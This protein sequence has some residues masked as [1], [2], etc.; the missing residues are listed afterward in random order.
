MQKPNRECKYAP[1]A[2]ISIT[3]PSLNPQHQWSVNHLNELKL[4][5]ITDIV[6]ANTLLSESFVNQLNEKFAKPAA[7]PQDAH[8]PWSADND[9]DQIL[10]WE[11]T[12]QIKNDWTVQLDNQYFQIEKTTKVHPKQQITIRRH[13]DNSI[14]LWYKTIRLPFTA[15]AK[16][17]LIVKSAQLTD[18]RVR[19]EIS[20]QNKHK[21]P[22]SRFNPDWLKAKLK[23][24]EKEV[25]SQAVI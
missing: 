2:H 21:T 12:R 1:V 13:L 5:K 3:L 15:I 23:K 6:G 8:V 10:C 7:D 25:A 24:T 18:P 11:F 17:A 4:R 9:L 22:W 19:A 14:S 20:R 16:P